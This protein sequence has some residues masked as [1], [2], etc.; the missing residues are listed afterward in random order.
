MAK[1]AADEF[2]PS[3][4]SLACNYGRVMSHV[5]QKGFQAGGVVGLGAVAPVVA[6]LEHRKGRTAEES[7]PVVAQALC[8]TALTTLAV[9]AALGV[10][11]LASVDDLKDGL[12][13]RAYRLHYNQ[14]QNRANLFANLGIAAG[15]TAAIVCLPAS[16]CMVVGG[17]AAGAAAG[18][19]AHVATWR[20]PQ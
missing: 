6:F 4:S 20:K 19:F 15:G 3:Q 17:A 9:S 12:E 10:A 2:D 11:R 14:G 8:R 1:G 13:D 16:A 5:L 18:I 7:L